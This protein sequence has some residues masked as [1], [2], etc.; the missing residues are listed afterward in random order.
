[1][2]ENMKL[3]D[4]G[5]GWRFRGPFVP[6]VLKG[7]RFPDRDAAVRAADDAGYE[8]R[9]NGDVVERDPDTG[10]P[11]PT[12]RAL[13]QYARYKGQYPGCV[14]LFRMGG[15]FEA[16]QDDARVV[17]GTLGLTLYEGG[18]VGPDQA[19]FPAARLDAM[20]RRLIRA[21]HRV[22]VC[23]EVGTPVQ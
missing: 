9:D 18:S 15:T 20:L 19:G 13:A 16:F 7:V 11:V 17:A 1:M 6:P 22:A 12:D 23:D 14:L 5:S 8:C 3:V 2:S 4:V 10:R 21:G